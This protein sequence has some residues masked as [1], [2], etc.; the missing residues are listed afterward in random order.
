V[1]A[2]EL[3]L[4]FPG[5]P[6]MR[7]FSLLGVG[8]SSY[9]RQSAPAEEPDWVREVVARIEDLILTFTGYGYRRVHAQLKSDGLCIGQ[10][11]VL[12]LMKEHSLL[13]H[14]KRKW[15]RT[16]D[17]DHGL[18]VYPNLTKEF[19]P[20]DRNQLW[21]SD[22]TYIHLPSGF[23]YLAAILDAYSRKAVAWHLSRT[24]DAELALKP[25]RQA[26]KE[27]S[28][29]AGWIHHSDRGVQYACRGYAQA[30]QDAG[31]RLSMSAKASPRENAKA[32]SFFATL[33]KEEVYLDD[34]R[35]FAEAEV[36]VNRFIGKIYNPSRLH[37]S[38]GNESPDI[39]EARIQRH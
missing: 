28:P 23:C 33:K 39:F 26:L 4:E 19:V 31:G 20:S 16:T 8:S 13:C 38:L 14:V 27:R 10:H 24:L 5:V 2:R 35:S 32:E 30:V 37:S 15:T 6:A 18:A 25:L 29:A 36:A 1:I 22:I 21:V 17:S 7:I 11:T 3:A 34:Y 9:Y 12:R